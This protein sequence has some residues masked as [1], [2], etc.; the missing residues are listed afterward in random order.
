METSHQCDRNHKYICIQ[1][2]GV[3]S[4]YFVICHNLII[5]VM[6]YFWK[7]S[8]LTCGVRANIVIVVTINVE[9]L[10]DIKM[11]SLIL[12]PHHLRFGGNTLNYHNYCDL[13]KFVTC[14]SINVHEDL[15]ATSFHSFSKV[16]FRIEPHDRVNWDLYLTSPWTR[17]IVNNIIGYY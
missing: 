13:I 15:T 12:K 17:L 8:F 5:G 1:I 6:N 10:V 16:S 2:L 14:Y 9:I 11:Y 4:D 3:S 7:N